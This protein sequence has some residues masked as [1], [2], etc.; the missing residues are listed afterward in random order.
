MQIQKNTSELI[1]TNQDKIVQNNMILNNILFKDFE[2]TFKSNM[3]ID[4]KK[5]YQFHLKHAYKFFCELRTNKKVLIISGF[6][7]QIIYKVLEKFSIGFDLK[8]A[9]YKKTKELNRW[10]NNGRKKF[11]FNPNNILGLI[12]KGS[13][14]L[15]ELVQLKIIYN[16]DNF[17]VF[18]YYSIN[19]IVTMFNN[20][21]SDE[22]RL[23]LIKKYFNKKWTIFD[24]IHL[25]KPVKLILLD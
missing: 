11:F 15:D 25:H 12:K 8:I 10:I 7:R 9:Y 4:K 17:S 24:E 1:E 6:I 23:K 5:I 3:K 20:N 21:I 22:E 19:E 14:I 2:E 16:N 13:I 18:S